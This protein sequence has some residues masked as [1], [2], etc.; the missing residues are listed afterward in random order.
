[1]DKFHVICT[2][3]PLSC[4]VQLDID[5]NTQDV[6]KVSYNRC[7]KGKDYAIKEF[8]APERTLTTTVPITGG[9][10]PLVPV[11][12]DRPIPKPLLHDAMKLTAQ[13]RLTAPVKMGDV[14][15]ENILDT[16]ANLVTTRNM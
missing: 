7:P 14:V 9:I 12:T 1:M 3:C 4:E 6:K 13:V 5:P 8:I 11:R 2:V 16:G 10:H 15:I